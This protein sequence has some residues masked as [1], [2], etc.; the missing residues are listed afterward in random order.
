MFNSIKLDKNLRLKTKWYILKNIFKARKFQVHDYTGNY[1]NYFAKRTDLFK[2]I[3]SRK[4]LTLADA[5]QVVKFGN[6]K[7]QNQ[8][9][10]LIRQAQIKDT[11]FKS[12][13]FDSKMAESWS[14]MDYGANTGILHEISVGKDL[15]GMYSPVTNSQAEFIL[16]NNEKIITFQDV[17][18]DKEKD[19]FKFK[20]TISKVK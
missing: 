9:I 2:Y 15:E 4:D 3:M 14:A 17:I 8:I 10:E 5:M 1:E 11:R 16:N 18:Y 12:L 20:S 6:K 7:Y 19:I 13:T